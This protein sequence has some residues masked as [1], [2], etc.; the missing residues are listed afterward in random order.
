LKVANAVA[1]IIVS[2]FEADA[3]KKLILAKSIERISELH[4]PTR[5]RIRFGDGIPNGR[6]QEI[7][8][9]DT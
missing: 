7:A 6:F 8:A 5:I 1:C 2:A 4:F 9:E 3:E